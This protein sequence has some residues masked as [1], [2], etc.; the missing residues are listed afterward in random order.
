MSKLCDS[1]WAISVWIL[2]TCWSLTGWIVFFWFFAYILKNKEITFNVP[3]F[4][5]SRVSF[6]SF[7]YDW[8]EV[9]LCYTSWSW[10]TYIS[11]YVFLLYLVNQ[12]Y[13]S[14]AIQFFMNV[15]NNETYW[16]KCV[17]MF[18]I[19]LDGLIHTSHVL[20]NDQCAYIFTK[21]LGTQ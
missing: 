3:F 8:V 20:T 12:H 14:A 5:W 10:Y 19:I 13:I 15:Q 16:S 21:A 17:I 18:E 2:L 4:R 6:N 9:D 1:D 7:T 11:S